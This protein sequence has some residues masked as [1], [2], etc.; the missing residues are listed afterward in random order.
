MRVLFQYLSDTRP[1]Q[2]QD[3]KL[4]EPFGVQA[5]PTIIVVSLGNFTENTPGSVEN[6]ISRSGL[7]IRKFILE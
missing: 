2:A 1:H 4:T 6:I 3:K 7:L 5:K